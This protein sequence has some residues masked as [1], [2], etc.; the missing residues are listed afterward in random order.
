[1]EK[2]IEWFKQNVKILIIGGLALCLGGG[3][4]LLTQP[5]N[6][7][8]TFS[9]S[10]ITAVS[11][12]KKAVS[13]DSHQGSDFSKEK[14]S[15][16]IEVDL[17]GAVKIPRVYT[18]PKDSRVDEL[19]QMAGGFTSEADQNTVNL[20]AKLKDESVIYV[21]KKEEHA[22]S[23]A[24]TAEIT[25]PNASSALTENS[26]TQKVNI[27]TADLTG[28]QTLSG[29]GAKKAQDIIDYRTQHGPFQKVEDLGNVKGFGDKTIEKLKE[30]IT[31]D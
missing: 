27:N 6:P 24:Q 26:A 25:T 1:M 2:L 29:V 28:L 20:A 7:P 4:Y 10:D 3:F 17:K 14:A 16:K 9:P 13:T 21:A 22:P 15:E 18:M 23:V 12:D 8:E 19:I 11:T 31:V 5:K 30:N